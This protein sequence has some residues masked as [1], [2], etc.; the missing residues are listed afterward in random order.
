MIDNALLTRD[1]R[2]REAEMLEILT[3]GQFPARSPHDNLADLRAQ[4]AA[5][6]KGAAE[7]HALVED[8]GLN[9]V[10]AYMGHVRDNAAQA[11]RRVIS[12]LREGTCRYEL[13]SGAYHRGLHRCRP[14]HPVGPHRLHRDVGTATGQLQRARVGHHGRDPL[15]LPHA[16]RRR[17]PAQLRL[18]RTHRGHNPRGQHA[19]RRATPLRLSPA[20]SKPRKQ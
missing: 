20:T 10:T 7:L 3:G 19:R 6:E 5:N 15:R 9:V 18:P 16:G 17:D 14:R 4:L 12:A 1:G 2:M 8:F 11:V 13:D